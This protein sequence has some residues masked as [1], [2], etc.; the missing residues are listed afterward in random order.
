[1]NNSKLEKIQE[2][3]LKIVYNESDSTYQDLM[4]RFGTCTM[5]HSRLKSIIFEVFKSLKGVNPAYI[6]DLITMKN[7]PYSL[8]KSYILEQGKKNTT[9]Y[10]LRSF[11]YLGSKL[12]NDLPEYFK[13]VTELEISEFKLLLKNLHVPNHNCYVNPIV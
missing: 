8:R 2:R 7:Q 13:Y 12:W 10:G 4:L 11:T 1:M 9:N 3:A 6:Q 5:L